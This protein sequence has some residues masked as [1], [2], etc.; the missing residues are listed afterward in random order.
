MAELVFGRAFSMLKLVENRFVVELI[1][2]ATF[3]A[4]VC[5]QMPGLANWNIDKLFMPKIR[6]IRDQYITV[7]RSMA[8]QRMK[9]KQ[10]R[11][12]LFSHLL[13]AKDPETGKGFT[14]DELWGEAT[15]LTVA[16]GY[17][18]SQLDFGV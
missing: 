15:M 16:G 3:R 18:S 5:L 17:I 4:G 2:L 10:E 12:D 9:I 11:R 8:L 13:D 14:L 7:S 6:K 1:K